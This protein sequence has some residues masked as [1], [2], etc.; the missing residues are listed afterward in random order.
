[1]P[2][3][4]VAA[5]FRL[6]DQV[7]ILQENGVDVLLVAFYVAEVG[8]VTPI[9]PPSPRWDQTSSSLEFDQKWMEDDLTNG[10]DLGESTSLLLLNIMDS[11]T[12]DLKFTLEL[13]SQFSSGCLPIL[14]TEL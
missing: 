9:I 13:P 7:K 11:L 1:M 14:D 4:A 2:L 12:Q 3:T 5:K 8:V 6:K 10:Q